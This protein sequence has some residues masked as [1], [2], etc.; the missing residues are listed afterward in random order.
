MNE[1]YR[2][3]PLTFEQQLQQ[4]NN[5]GLKVDDND[6]ALSHL[7]TISYYRL[8]IYWYPFRRE[9]KIGM[10]SDEF[11]EG[12][13]LDE[14]MK[15]YNF[16]RDLRLLVMDAI[17]RI[18]VHVRSLFAYRMGH[19]YGAFGHTV[20]ANFAPNFKHAEWLGK[21]NDATAKRDIGK[22][23]FIT[24]Y[25]KKYTGFPTLPVWMATEVMSLGNL[26]VGY[27]GMKSKDKKYIS[28]KFALDFRYLSSWLHTITHVRNICSHH[29]RLWN[30]ELGIRPRMLQQR[31]WQPPI[32]PGNDRVFYVLLILR[33]LLSFDSAGNEWKERVG[34]LLEPIAN[35]DRW[36][37]AMGMSEEWKN[38]PVWK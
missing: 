6:I 14:V 12:A 8:S 36:R 34:K 25:K 37:I 35:E 2:K 5:R 21:I 18:E 38:H 26:S 9:E 24:S 16:D 10:K 28:D 4:L 17:E 7:K 22:E 23:E 27:K 11:K 15:L 30:R 31:N 20:A 3:P 32:T 29:G 19:E 33:Y 1:E 13:H